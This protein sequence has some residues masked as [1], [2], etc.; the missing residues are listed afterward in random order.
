MEPDIITV[1]RNAPLNQERVILVAYTAF[2][3]SGRRPTDFW[4]KSLKF[5]G[6]LHEII[7]EA[8]L[9]P[10]CDD[11]S[12]EEFQP[13]PIYIN[14]EQQYELVINEQVA[15]AESRFVRIV[16]KKN[17]TSGLE[18]EKP[19]E[20]HFCNFKPGCIVIIK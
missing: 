13:D 20:I 17:S 12:F 9:Q 11:T 3:N 14:G 2:K 16:D 8:E 4:I 19:T 7:L 1:T 18:S 5:E 10:I 15:L 6:Q